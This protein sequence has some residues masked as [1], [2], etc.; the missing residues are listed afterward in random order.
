MDNHRRWMNRALELARRGIGHV[1]PNPMVGCVVVKGGRVIAE[2]YHHAYAKDH[3]EVDALKKAGTRARGAD[4]YV[5]LEPCAHW[6]KTPPCMVAVVGSGIRRVYAAMQDPNPK[7]AGKGFTFLKQH[8]VR[9][10]RGIL[11]A[12][13]RELNR[14]FITRILE[15]RPY[16]TLKAAVSL[17]GKIATARG[18]SQWIT[19]PAARRRGHAFRAQLDAVAVGIGT[20]LRD[21]PGL[22][23]HGAGRDPKRVIFDSHLRLPRTAKVLRKRAQTLVLTTDRSPLAKRRALEKHG[24][25]VYVVSRDKQGHVSIPEALRV[26]AREGITDLLVEGGGSLNAA[27]LEAGLVD[28]V[29]WFIAPKFIGGATAKTAVEGSGVGRL[30]DAWNLK[31]IRID[32]VGEDILL[33]GRLRSG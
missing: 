26:L 4:L 18:E 10:T 7:V 19:G 5:N 27:F 8:G 20:V 32:Q 17:D 12:E 33:K 6:G 15:N 11:E 22:T 28:E 31:D 21:N 23:A 24:S 3:A 9:V 29:I 14:A 2:G 30:A 1:H 13:A 16:V 25:S